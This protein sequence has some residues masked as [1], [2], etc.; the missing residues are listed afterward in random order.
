[1]FAAYIFWKNPYRPVS[2]RAS[3]GAAA[4]AIKSSMALEWVRHVFPPP[5]T[6]FG[7]DCRDYLLEAGI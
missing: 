3:A 1:M 4:H 7:I 5:A 2:V 6:I